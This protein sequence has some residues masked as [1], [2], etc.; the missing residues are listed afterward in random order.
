MGIFEKVLQERGPA[1]GV[2][3]TPRQ[4]FAAIVIGAC[5]ADG[6]VSPE[7]SV[8]L[9]EL[10]N[11]T[12]LFRQPSPEPVQAVLDRVIQLIDS[13]SADAVVALAA[14]A[15]PAELHP[16][17]FAIAADLVLADGQA[18]VEERAFVDR[19]Q[20]LLE[21]SDEEAIRI[22]DVIVLKNSV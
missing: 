20:E 15:L 12:R 3:L 7:E 18:G 13:H 21:I 6:R 8:R 19:L 22:V 1:E 16:P 5:R 4:A 11:S 17:A 14:K 10:F 2:A 9:N